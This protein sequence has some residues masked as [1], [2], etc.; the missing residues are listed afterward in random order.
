MIPIL[1]IVAGLVA[2]TAGGELL[3][4]GAARMA[5]SLKISPLV[6][7]LTVVA[8]GT[9]SPE[10]AVSLN[11]SL[12]GQPDISI[13]NVVGSNI[14]N[15]LFILGVSA[16]IVPL[17][18]SS[19]LIR[20]DVPV[21]IAASV[22]VW[23]MC[24]DGNIG[25]T[26]GVILAAGIVVYTVWL[27]WQSRREQAAVI[28]E[29]EAEFGEK[30]MATKNRLVVNCVLVIVGLVLLAFGSGWLVDGAITIARNLGISELV[31]GLT[32]VAAGTSLPEVAASVMAS[33]RGERDIAVGNIVGSNIFNIFCVLGVSAVFAPNGINVAASAL[34]MDIPV[35][36]AV[37]VACLPVF[38]TGSL[39]A[40]W[41]GIVFLG[42]YAAYVT[43]LVLNSSGH[44]ATGWFANIILWMAV[45]LTV[46]TLAIAVWRTVLEQRAPATA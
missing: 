21:M 13:G 2:L 46:L 35:M 7:G 6:I 42:Y 24:L 11:A 23:L 1:L 10:L 43:F 5:N 27:V 14:F 3:V 18:V 34:Q 36:I 9:S 32:I 28:A 38:F 4:R 8:F 19:Q 26:D 15:V 33:I 29:Y 12:N 31:I 37:A 40:R 44:P 30:S 25:W 22:T 20:F 41:E 17:A 39:I 16:L 45:P